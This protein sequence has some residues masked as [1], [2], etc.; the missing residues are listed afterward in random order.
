VN[1]FLAGTACCLWILGLAVA[2]P[3]ERLLSLSSDPEEVHGLLDSEELYRIGV[4][5][6][7]REL[8]DI[9]EL[10]VLR[11]TRLEISLPDLH[12]L[13]RGE[14]DREHTDGK[15]KQ[16]V[17]ELSDW[18]RA[19]PEEG[20]AF[21]IPVEEERPVL[22]R[23]I[24]G[25]LLERLGAGEECGLGDQIRIGWEA[26]RDRLGDG[27][28]E[29]EVLRDLPDCRPPDRVLEPIEDRLQERMTELAEEGPDSI[30]A[31]P[32][33]EEDADFVELMDRIW[34][35]ERW[36]GQRGIAL[37]GV[38]LLGLFATAMASPGG[39]RPWRRLTSRPAGL[40]AGLA[41]LAPS[42]ATAGVAV[43]I[44]GVL[45][46]LH[47]TEEHLRLE[48]LTGLGDEAPSDSR[49][50]WLGIAFAAIGRVT[51]R[52]GWETAVLGALLLLAGI[53]L[54]L[55]LA[56]TRREAETGSQPQESSP[57]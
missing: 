41:L 28:S 5:G 56:L 11:G 42:L 6:S 24:E 7:A 26:L 49:V 36:L 13:L 48:H 45:L 31:F 33:D 22:A 46:L 40:R 15:A 39:V 43:G 1:R 27:R 34:T 10:E 3:A 14:F 4:S 51:A 21:R 35:V 53:A 20:G 30:R 50:R 47:S 18:V 52:A 19:F 12:Q 38:L 23:R 16:I 32:D 29:I 2:V 8:Q 54:G 9:E 55:S 57:R 25:E 37:I 17:R 44:S